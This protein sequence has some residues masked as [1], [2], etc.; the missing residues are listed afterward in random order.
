MGENDNKIIDEN[1]N[2]I[3]PN[4][5]N[6]VNNEVWVNMNNIKDWLTET[7]WWEVPHIWM[8]PEN[9]KTDSFVNDATSTIISSNWLN[10]QKQDL[11]VE[12]SDPYDLPWIS[13]NKSTTDTL[14]EKLPEILPEILPTNEP[15]NDTKPK[16]EVVTEEL[17]NVLPAEKVLWIWVDTYDDKK[18]WISSKKLIWLVYFVI[19]VSILIWFYF[20][21]NQNK[22]MDDNL[23]SMSW[24][25]INWTWDNET[26]SSTVDESLDSKWAVNESWNTSASTTDKNETWWNDTTKASSWDSSKS[27]E[28]IINDFEDELDSLFDMIDKNDK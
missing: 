23:E 13:V 4:A 24:E 6:W 25:L 14:D 16:D 18:N 15:K 17:S 1:N 10:E 21:Y 26:N 3:N 27:E 11:K 2:Q 22:N 28:A 5:N 12:S 20:Y 7:L 19:F 9:I 8:Q